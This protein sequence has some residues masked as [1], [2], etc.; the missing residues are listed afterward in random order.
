MPIKRNT[1]YLFN[2]SIPVKSQCAACFISTINK[3]SLNQNISTDKIENI[4][5]VFILGEIVKKTFVTLVNTRMVKISIDKMNK[6]KPI[7]ISFVRLT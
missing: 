3:T 7:V 5:Y 6:R 4:K 1:T 2:N